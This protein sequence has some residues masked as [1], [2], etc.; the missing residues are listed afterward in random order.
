MKAAD[1]VDR[2]RENLPA[3]TDAFTNTLSV[4]SV[5]VDAEVATATTAL[6]HGLEIG[7]AAYLA[8]TQRNIL[9]E[10]F[11]R[12]GIVGTIVT[13]EDHDLTTGEA[14]RRGGVN[15]INAFPLDMEGVFTAAGVPNRRTITVVM[16]DSGSE[17]IVFGQLVGA[18][19]Y[20]QEINGLLS[21]ASV[22]SPTTFTFAVPAGTPDPHSESVMSVRTLP[23]VSMAINADRIQEVYTAQDA[24]DAWAFVVLGEVEASRNRKAQVD[25]VSNISQGSFF[26]QQV[27]QPFSI[28]VLVSCSDT[29][30]GAEA[31]DIAETL[32]QPICQSILF[33]TFDSYLTAGSHGAV[34]F[35]RHASVD[36]T[37]AVYTHEYM[38]EVVSELT[39]DDTVGHAPNVAFRD[40]ATEITPDLDADQGDGQQDGSVNLDEVPL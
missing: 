2:L 9:L 14:S 33:S 27:V 34:Q 31:R 20:H 4:V 5:T 29:V 32:L 8:G 16:E 17:S 35:V 30:G 11:E 25:A 3:Y 38:F 23:R 7:N 26:R 21:V 1:V 13:Q 22:P 28:V 36:Y 15:V 10:S 12:S 24:G 40:L 6:A 37:P 19:A 39:F 18:A